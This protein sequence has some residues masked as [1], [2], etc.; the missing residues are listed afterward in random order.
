MILKW[1]GEQLICKIVVS[2]EIH[3]CVDKYVHL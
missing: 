1:E 3:T 2:R